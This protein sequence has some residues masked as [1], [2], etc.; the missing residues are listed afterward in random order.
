MRAVEHTPGE[1]PTYRYELPTRTCLLSVSFT[2]HQDFPLFRSCYS[3][4][5][6][7]TY[8]RPTVLIDGMQLLDR[9]S[10]F[11]DALKKK[12]RSLTNH[13]S[14]HVDTQYLRLV[15]QSNA[16]ESSFSET[17][18]PLCFRQSAIGAKFRI[19][20]QS[21]ALCHCATHMHRRGKN[22]RSVNSLLCVDGTP[23]PIH[24]PR[25]RSHPF[26]LSRLDPNLLGGSLEDVGENM[27]KGSRTRHY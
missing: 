2:R 26:Q 4:S 12:I 14:Y 3:I 17:Q 5:H 11:L 10:K 27:N 22:R 24:I 13:M 1:A 7:I 9:N 18:N 19:K 15:V 20:N 6:D 16:T 23:S 8:C 25:P 21:I